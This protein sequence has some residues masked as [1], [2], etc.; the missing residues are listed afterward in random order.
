MAS[1]DS[2][3]DTPLDFADLE[4]G[5]EIGRGAF[6]RVYV[7]TYRGCEAVAIKK[8]TLAA[9]DAEKYLMSELGI[10]K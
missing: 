10:L 3:V 7:G 6:S 5:K 1:S 8:I 9:K 2:S 4:I